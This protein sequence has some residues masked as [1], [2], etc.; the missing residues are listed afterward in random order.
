MTK[1]LVKSYIY[2]ALHIVV[3]MGYSILLVPILLGFWDLQVYGTWIAL[4]AIYNLI[5]VLELGHSTYVGNSINHI[6]HKDPHQAKVILGSALRANFLVGISQIL[7][8]GAIYFTG[9]LA[10]LLDKDIDIKEVAIVLSILLFYRMSLGSIRGIIVKVLNPFGMIYKAFQFKLTEKILE[11][12][13]LVVAAFLDLSLIELAFLWLFVKWGY[14]SIILWQLKKLMPDFFPWWKYGSFK[15]G[16]KNLKTGTHYIASNFLDRLGNDGIVLVVSVIVGTAY[17]PLFSATRTLV[18]FGL[19]LSDFLLKPMIPEMINLFAK[20]RLQTILDIFKSY[21]FISG[22]ILLGGFASSLL[23]VEPVFTFWTK[24]KLEFDLV[25]YGALVLVFVIQNY[26]KVML[27]F[28]T[29]INKTKVVLFASVLRISLFF[30][31]SFTLSSWGMNGVL[32][33]LLVAELVIVS[34]WFPPKTITT[35]ALRGKERLMIYLNLISVFVLA[36]LFYLHWLD[37]PVIIQAIPALVL[38]VLLWLQYVQISE[39][40]RKRVNKQLSR[41]LPIKRSKS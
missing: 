22:I 21:W 23:F 29:G 1:K 18:N 39:Q 15:I 5:Q 17:L 35:F 31:I 25:L 3:L 36:I 12:F 4:Y 6:V 13:I 14:S 8:V 38:V 2:K 26:G 11:F 33:A 24:G 9:L 30:I 34:F 20:D 7:I 19:K 16:Y 41:F 28:F 37:Q 10:F 40:M 32:I 27:V